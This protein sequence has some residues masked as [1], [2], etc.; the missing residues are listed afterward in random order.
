MWE[1]ESGNG[2]WESGSR[3]WERVGGDLFASLYPTPNP[4]PYNNTIGRTLSILPVA[5]CYMLRE[6]IA[7]MF[8]PM[9]SLSAA[10][11]QSISD[12]LNVPHIETRWDFRDEDDDLFSINLH[13]HYETLSHAFIDFIDYLNWKTFTILYE[14]NNSK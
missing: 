8:G 4:L 9:S 11:V 3:E 14:D 7:G 12:S 10:H 6:G 2:E 5:V 13:P 1:W